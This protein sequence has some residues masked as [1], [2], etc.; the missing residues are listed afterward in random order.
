M[1][2][3]TVAPGPF[4]FLVGLTHSSRRIV[5]ELVRSLDEREAG[6]SLFNAAH[7]LSRG[8][9]LALACLKLSFTSFDIFDY[10]RP[11]FLSQTR[12][13][14]P[15]QIFAFILTQGIGAFDDFSEC[16]HGCMIARTRWLGNLELFNSFAGAA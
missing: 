14:N 2:H 7:D 8:H 5:L 3:Q 12:L 11:A 15:D 9:G 13:Q 1:R 16:C 10:S 6:A 4:E